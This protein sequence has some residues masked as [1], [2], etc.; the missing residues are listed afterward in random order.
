MYSFSY[1]EPVWCSMSSSTLVS[2]FSCVYLLSHFNSVWLFAALWTVGL[3]VKGFS[4]QEYWSGLP[5]PP[6]GYLPH[7][8]IEP[9]SLMSPAFAGRFFTP[10]GKPLCFHKFRLKSPQQGM[11]SSCMFWVS[12]PANGWLT[13]YFWIHFPENENWYS[14]YIFTGCIQW[15]NTQM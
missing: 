6:P 7:P 12:T 9:V 15:P 4:L 5:F 14:S 1:L 2:T 13:L 8:G 11:S 10:T 3:S